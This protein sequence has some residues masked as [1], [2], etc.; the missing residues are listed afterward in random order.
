M[1]SVR[2]PERA[3]GHANGPGNVG[4]HPGIKS[5][6]WALKCVL[7]GIPKNDPG[8]RQAAGARSDR[9]RPPA[10]GQ[11][12]AWLNHSGR[13]QLST[14]QPPAGRGQNL[15]GGLSAPSAVFEKSSLSALSGSSTMSALS[16]YFCL[17]CSAFCASP[18]GLFGVRTTSCW[19]FK[20]S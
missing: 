17:S 9:A 3:T 6:E 14:G 4:Y 18:S 10:P 12:K 19:S 16:R 5:R 13:G 1:P 8:K 11:E 7:E 20:P 15:S 2:Q